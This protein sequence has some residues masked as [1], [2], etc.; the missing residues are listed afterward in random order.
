MGFEPTTPHSAGQGAL[1]NY[2][3]EQ[4]TVLRVENHPEINV[5]HTLCSS[6]QVSIS[7]G[8]YQYCL[9]VPM[10]NDLMSFVGKFLMKILEKSCCYSSQIFRKFLSQLIIRPLL[11]FFCRV[12]IIV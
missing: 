9:R 10:N 6:S 7:F 3:T 11:E 1:T 5:R 8:G 4:V 2:A 12:I